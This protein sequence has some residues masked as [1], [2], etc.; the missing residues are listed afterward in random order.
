MFPFQPLLD[1]TRR[2]WLDKVKP[3]NFS[4]FGETHRTNNI[5]ESRNSRWARELGKSPSVWQFIEVLR[6]FERIAYVDF[7]TLA[8]VDPQA[9]LTS[10]RA[11]KRARVKNYFLQQQWSR[12]SEVTDDNTIA[13]VIILTTRI[14]IKNH[15]Y[16]YEFKYIYICKYI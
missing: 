6:E 12:L 15:L 2:F 14:I 8:D 1:Y 9:K 7:R 11:S 4:V 16:I 10:Q 13:D 5:C 3:K